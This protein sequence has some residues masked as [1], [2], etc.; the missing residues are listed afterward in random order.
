M[1]QCLS[2]IVPRALLFFTLEIK[3]RIEAA[4]LNQILPETKRTTHAHKG[5]GSPHAGLTD[6][7]EMA[8]LWIGFQHEN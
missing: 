5:P 7:V 6:L 4:L 1:E 2:E 3:W 8:K